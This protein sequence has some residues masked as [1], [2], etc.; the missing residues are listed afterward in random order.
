MEKLAP[1]LASPGPINEPTSGL[2]LTSQEVLER[3]AVRRKAFLAAGIAAGDRVFIGT[4]TA[5]R[6][7]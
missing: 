4:A 2:S 3:F 5:L 1:F 6:F 7:F